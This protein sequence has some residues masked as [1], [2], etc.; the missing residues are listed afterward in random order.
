M[1]AEPSAASPIRQLLDHPYWG[2]AVLCKCLGH[3]LRRRR[4]LLGIPPKAAADSIR[5]STSKISRLENG[6]HRFQERDVTDLLTLYQVIDAA[7]RDE[8]MQLVRLA[9]RPNWWQE[10]SDVLPDWFEPLIGAESAAQLIR[11]YETNLVPGWLQTEEYAAVVT[12]AGRPLASAREVER[13]VELRM[14]RAELLRRTQ[15]PPLLWALMDEAVLKRPVGNPGVMRRQIQHL[16]GI[17]DELPR[18]VRLQ[19]TPWSA[20]ASGA[21][22]SPVVH[23]RFPVAMLPDVVY[24]EQMASAL[25]IEKPAATEEYRGLLDF[26]SACSL[27]AVR[28]RSLLEE[29]L[30][31]GHSRP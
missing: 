8:F 6:L 28:T 15:S 13:S 30:G 21:M 11:C 26:L 27:P 18:V 1:V 24:L 7:E 25:F 9:G 16:I 20:G 31:Q 12:R 22:G 14:R 4:E 17:L 10:Y 19:I 2:S 3:E 23:I 29:A 5:A